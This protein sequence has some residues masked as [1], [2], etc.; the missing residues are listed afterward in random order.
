MSDIST[1]YDAMLTRLAA[2]YPSHKRLENPYILDRNSDMLL[3]Q[4]YGLAI[5]PAENTERF[6]SCQLS[7]R[8]DMIVSITRVVRANEFDIGKKDSAWKT[9]MED[10]ALLI[11]DVEADPTLGSTE[12]VNAK[13]STDSGIQPIFGDKDNF[14][15]VVTVVSIEYFENL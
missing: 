3:N 6:S 5:G 8:R 15:S 11:A 14:V 12:V 7:V 9:V 10:Q 2:L 1:A 4:G 13:Y